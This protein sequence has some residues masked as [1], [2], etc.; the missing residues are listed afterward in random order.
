[1]LKSGIGRHF[2]DQGQGR[3]FGNL[4]GGAT[5]D[6][7]V[8]GADSQFKN[9]WNFS[10]ITLHDSQIWNSVVGLF[11]KKLPVEWEYSDDV[12]FIDENLQSLQEFLP[13]CQ[14]VLSEWNLHVNEG[15][16]EFVHFYLPS[17]LVSMILTPMVP[18]S[19][20][21]KPGE[22]ARAS[23][24]C[25]ALRLTSRVESAWHTQR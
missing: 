21:M 18:F 3:H 20:I 15:K 17:N 25:S 23:T 4:Q 16:T 10:N 9:A 24:H 1:M 5:E 19:L 7:Y 2:G 22:C 6:H 11:I 13:T 12:D 8:T 14:E